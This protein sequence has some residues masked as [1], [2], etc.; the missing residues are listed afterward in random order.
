MTVNKIQALFERLLSTTDGMKAAPMPD[1]HAHHVA[2]LAARFNR[3]G[4]EDEVAELVASPDQ[5][6]ARLA[7]YL[8]GGLDEM[9]GDAVRARL[10]QSPAA[11]YDAESAGAFLDDVAAQPRTA[12]ADLVALALSR[13]AVQSV[14][15]RRRQV[16]WS[17]WLSGLVTAAAAATVIWVLIANHQSVGP[18]PSAPMTA[19]TVPQPGSVTPPDA[20]PKMVPAGSEETVPF[21]AKR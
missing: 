6:T 18:A 11:L 3:E 8:D 12:P 15:T 10:V 2:G 14:P 7:A 17:W 1:E 9:S 4:G 19:D 21:P 5:S 13:S 20:S 16:S